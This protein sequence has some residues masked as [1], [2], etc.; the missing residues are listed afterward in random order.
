[1]WFNAIGSTTSHEGAVITSFHSWY[2]KAAWPF[3]TYSLTGRQPYSF[4]LFHFPFLYDSCLAKFILNSLPSFSGRKYSKTIPACLAYK[5]C[6]LQTQLTRSRFFTKWSYWLS[7]KR[8]PSWKFKYKYP[9]HSHFHSFTC[10]C[11][12]PT[13]PR[14]N[15]LPPSSH[16]CSGNFERQIINN[17]KIFKD[18]FACKFVL[19]ANHQQ[20]ES[21]QRLFRLQVCLSRKSWTTRKYSKTFSPANLS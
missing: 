21:I 12:L 7:L 20:S 8:R 19:A 13:S 5:F 11:Q 4:P 16:Q 3:L 1:M 10:R 15:S 2:G 9:A 18:F 17:P 6:C 14:R